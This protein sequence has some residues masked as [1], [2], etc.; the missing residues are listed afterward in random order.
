VAERLIVALDVPTIREARELS[1]KLDGT[2]SFFKVGLWRAFA[3]G[4]DDLIRHLIG[5]GKKLFLD[6]KMFG[7]MSH[8]SP[9]IQIVPK[10]SAKTGSS[11]SIA[12]NRSINGS[13]RISGMVGIN[14]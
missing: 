12:A 11:A 1:E 6:N 14:S 4:V 2:V 9:H 7:I 13:S 8:D 10:V 5:S 3:E